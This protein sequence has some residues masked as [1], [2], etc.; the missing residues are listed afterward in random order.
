MIVAADDVGD[1]HVVIVDDDREHIGRRAVGAQHDDVVEL[2]VLHGHLALDASSMTVSPSRGAFRRI[3]GA[4]PAAPRRIAVAPA[5]IVAAERP[6]A[7]AVA[8]HRL[9]LLGVAKQR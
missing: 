5:A 1:A 3:D 4:S 7:R 2:V 8:A 9:D 6:S